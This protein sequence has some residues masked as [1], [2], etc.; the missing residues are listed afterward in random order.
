MTCD[1]YRAAASAELDGERD[2]G[3]DAELDA[4]RT[5]AEHLARCAECAAWLA[6]ARRLR[7]LSLAAPGPSEE[8]SRRL[9]ARVVEEAA[10]SGGRP[11]PRT[12]ADG[13]A[14]GSS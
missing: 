4:D 11:E 10:S 5:P 7:A 14:H 12:G 13:V 1:D 9:V 2:A 8:W 3:T 6:A